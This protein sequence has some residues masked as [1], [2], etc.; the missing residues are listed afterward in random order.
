[1]WNFSENKKRAEVGY[2]LNPIYQRKGIMN[3]AL[4]Q[5]I[6]FGFVDLNLDKI[7]AFTHAENENSLKLLEKNGFYIDEN[8][9]DEDNL[10][11]LIFV[12]KKTRY[13]GRK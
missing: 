7:E 10:N 5:I 9:K 8:R 6:E 1:L 2:D 3:E 13:N 12:I 11:N 4:K